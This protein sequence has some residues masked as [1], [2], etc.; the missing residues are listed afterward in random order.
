MANYIKNTDFA[1]KDAL[2]SGNPAKIIKGTE[3]DTEYNDIAIAISTKADLVSPT[4]TGTPLAPTA[5]SGTNNTQIATTAFVST[6]VSAATGALGTMSTQNANNVSISGGTITS[7]TIN[8]NTVGSNSV[9]NRTVQSTSAGVP[10]NSSGSDG[11]IIYQ[12]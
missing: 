9:G 11:D 4:F 7:T 6:A 8:S 1:S 2:L 10:S 3:I 12:Y 5:N